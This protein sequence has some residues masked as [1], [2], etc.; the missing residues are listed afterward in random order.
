MNCKKYFE[1]YKSINNKIEYKLE[2]IRKLEE[3]S[4]KIT[5]SNQ[6]EQVD[7]TKDPHKLA[8]LVEKISD[9]K[10]EIENDMIIML[11]TSKNINKTIS[12]IENINER[13]IIELHYIG[14]KTFE[15]IAE[16]LNY[17]TRQIYNLI[18]SL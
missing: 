12:K 8:K 13:K 5:K 1:E 18:K 9:Y 10:K 16:I 4:T 2:E 6:R 11:E 7:A 15:E 14:G 17:S 3:L